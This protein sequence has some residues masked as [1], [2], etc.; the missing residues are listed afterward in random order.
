[1]AISERNWPKSRAGCKHDEYINKQHRH[2][3]SVAD[4]TSKGTDGLESNDMD[5]NTRRRFEALHIPEWIE[6]RDIPDEEHPRPYQ[7]PGAFEAPW[8]SRQSQSAP[9]T[10]T[11][12]DIRRITATRPT[13]TATPARTNRVLGIRP[14]RHSDV[15]GASHDEDSAR[16][17]IICTSALPK[18]SVFSRI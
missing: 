4:K 15:L 7:G 6:I 10:P 8:R 13:L 1:M 5:N 16:Y 17:P 9:T 14:P 3:E 11:S 2:R 18:C 12:D